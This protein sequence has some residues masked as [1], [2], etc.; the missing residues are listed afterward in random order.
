MNRS[1]KLTCASGLLFLASRLC[2][3]AD[4]QRVTPAVAEIPIFAVSS[5]AYRDFDSHLRNWETKWLAQ[6]RSE[7]DTQRYGSDIRNYEITLFTN[8]VTVDVTFKIRPFHGRES[9]GGVTHYVLDGKTG[10]IL[11]HTG[12]K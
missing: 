10:A 1:V 12:E 7:S 11:Q 6:G 8:E 9:F 2:D 4:S 5:V 3:G